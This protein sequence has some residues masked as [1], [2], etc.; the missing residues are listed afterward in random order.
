MPVKDY[1]IIT[2]SS[3]RS[4]WT[5]VAKWRRL[6]WPRWT[7]WF[8]WKEGIKASDIHCRFSTDFGE[9]T[10]ARSTVFNLVRS[11]NSDKETTQVALSE[12]YC[13]KKWLRDAIAK[14]PRRG[15]HVSP[16]R[17]TFCSSSCLVFGLKVIELLPM[18]WVQI[19]SE[20]CFVLL[21]NTTTVLNCFIYKNVLCNGLWT[22]RSKTF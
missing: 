8:L 18:R 19:V 22:L 21:L 20:R 14:F 2:K 12:W 6:S 16:R 10:P 9:K 4:S 15:Q 1:C 11:L 3:G 5:G 17:T 7:T 13:L